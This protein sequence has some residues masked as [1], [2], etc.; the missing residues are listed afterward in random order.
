MGTLRKILSSTEEGEQLINTQQQ[1]EAE[2]AG[3]MDIVDESAPRSNTS[4]PEAEVN[5]SKVTLFHAI[6]STSGDIETSCLNLMSVPLKHLFNESIYSHYGVYTNDTEFNLIFSIIATSMFVGI[7]VGG[8]LMGFLMHV[9]GRKGTAIYVRCSLEILAATFMI[10]ARYFHSVELYAIAHFL[11]GVIS[12]LKMVLYIY[13]TECA[14][15][16]SRGISGMAIG[17]GSFLIML[18]IQSLCLPSVLGNDSRWVGL[19]IICLIV[20]VIHMLGGLFLPESPKHLYIIKDKKSEAIN[21]INYYHGDHIDTALIMEE[22]EREKEIISLGHVSLK[23][24]WQNRTLRRPFLICAICG[25]VSGAAAISIT[26]Q[27]QLSMFLTFGMTQAQGVLATMI[28][29]F[30]TLPLCLVSPV[31]IE[32]VGRRPLFLFVSGLCVI[33]WLLLMIARSMIDINIRVHVLTSVLGVVGALAGQV[34]VMMGLMI[35][36]PIIIGEL[37]PHVA[38]APVGQFVQI[39]PVLYALVSVFTYPVAVSHIGALFFLP[40][41]FVSSLLWYLMYKNLPETA[42]LPVDTIIRRLTNTDQSMESPASAS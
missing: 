24:V 36:T 1:N 2:I 11:A 23:Q 42:G 17:S 10:G 30:V 21:A 5:I 41:F 18:G 8:L 33:E 19:P 32:K 37:C 38:R 15:N 6:F 39:V 35:L 4:L 22:Y 28:I 16:D 31:V 29:S 34:S 26:S 7:I 12:T 25:M 3:D 14:P 20:A 40:F 13:M 9:F 27:Y